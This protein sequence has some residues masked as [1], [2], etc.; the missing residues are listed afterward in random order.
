MGR[1]PEVVGPKIYR[2]GIRDTAPSP[3]ATVTS[4][5]V[6]AKILG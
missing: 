5:P 3:N 6:R 4:W 2:D 1:A